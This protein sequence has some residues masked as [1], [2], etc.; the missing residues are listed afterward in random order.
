MENVKSKKEKVKFKKFGQLYLMLL[1]P[2]LLVL[3]FH[4]GSMVGIIMA[5]QDF[6]PGQGFYVFGSKFDHFENFKKLFSTPEVWNVFK[7]TLIIA[8]TKLVLGTAVPILIAILMNEI[9]KIWFKRGVQTIIFLPHFISWVILSGV[10]LRMFDVT[11]GVLSKVFPGLPDFFHDPKLFPGMLVG[12]ALWKDSGYSAI[13]YI[14]AIT[15]IDSSLYEAAKI[16][17]AGHIKRCIHVTLPGMLPVIIMMSVLHM[18]NVLNAGFEQVYNMYNMDV[19]STGDILDTFVYRRAF[20]GGSDYSFS[21]A[22]GLLKSV[23]SV[24]LISTSYYIAHKKFNYN[25]F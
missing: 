18:G 16:D 4:Y 25:I 2:M 8:I 9:G 7:N 1:A 13:V 15:T 21:T 20:A 14:A 5:F 23:I 19:Y 10:F 11:G 24:F 17:G 6:L 12:S 22:V 3:I